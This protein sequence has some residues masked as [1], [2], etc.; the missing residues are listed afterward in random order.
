MK[1]FKD[2]LL[3][4]EVTSFDLGECSLGETKTISYFVLN[5]TQARLRDMTVV[6]DLSEIKVKKN[7]KR[8]KS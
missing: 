8:D 5:D 3:T 7:E 1:I 2:I 6:I 4:Q